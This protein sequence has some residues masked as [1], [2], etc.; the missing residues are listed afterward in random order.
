MSE[1]DEPE[2]CY[3]C[4]GTGRTVMYAARQTKKCRRCKGSG[5]LPKG[6]EAEYWRLLRREA[7]AKSPQQKE[8]KG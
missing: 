1:A 4:S 7:Q 3:L 2:R 5:N 8:N 6:S